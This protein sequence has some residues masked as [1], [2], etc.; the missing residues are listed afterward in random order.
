LEISTRPVGKFSS[1][2]FGE[3]AHGRMDRKRRRFIMKFSSGAQIESL[4][5]K[6]WQ[7]RMVFAERRGY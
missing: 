6:H 1:R 7:G 5:K 2:I 4:C 3:T